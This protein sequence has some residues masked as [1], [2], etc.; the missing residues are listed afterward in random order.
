MTALAWLTSDDLDF[1][2]A[3]QALAEPNGLLAA[4]GD[5]SPERLLAAYRQG[6]FPW[7]EDG[8][9][10]L[11][12]SPDPRTVLYP[13]KIHISR[14]MRRLLRNNA[15]T[16]SCDQ[17]FEQV[18]DQC[19]ISPRDGQSGTWITPG[20]RQ[21]YINLH[22]R[23]H[24][25][26]IEAWQAEQLVGGLYGVVIG[27][28]FFGESMFSRVSNASKYAFICLANQLADWDFALIDCQVSTAHL[29][30]LGAETISRS[31]FLQVLDLAVNQPSVASWP[32]FLPAVGPEHLRRD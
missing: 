2:P 20:M 26:S 27:R 23:G 15:F 13:D 30:S 25:H 8:Q 16:V 18:I 32:P 12:W 3:E 31:C 4:G 5:L 14:S 24:A 1:P 22:Q 7:F 6:I 17:A 9:P 10:I 29:N 21:A 28:V 19:A 11:W